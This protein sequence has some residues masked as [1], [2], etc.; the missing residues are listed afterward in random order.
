MTFKLKLSTRPDD[1]LG[2]VATWD[3]AEQ[4]LESAL[5]GFTKSSGAVWEMNPKDGAFYGPKI[6]IAIMDALKRQYQVSSP[7][8]FTIA[9]LIVH[10]KVRHYP[11]GLSIASAFQP[12]IYDS[13]RQ[14][15]QPAA[16]QQR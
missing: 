3:K 12:N 13:R 1:F 5:N 14:K 2:D 16:K 8:V 4:A 11:V 10:L 9:L 15:Q 6:D 7:F